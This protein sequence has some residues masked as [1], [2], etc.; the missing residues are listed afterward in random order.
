M[1]GCARHL[2][3]RPSP[4]VWLNF[5]AVVPV[6]TRPTPSEMPDGSSRTLSSSVFRKALFTLR[7]S[8]KSGSAVW[9]IQGATQRV[10]CSVLF[11]RSSLKHLFAPLHTPSLLPPLQAPRNCFSLGTPA[12][13]LFP[14]AFAHITP[15]NLACAPVRHPPRERWAIEASGA[16]SRCA[17]AASCRARASPTAPPSGISKCHDKRQKRFLCSGNGCPEDEGC[18]T[19]VTSPPEMSSDACKPY[20]QLNILLTANLGFFFQPIFGSHNNSN[21]TT[22]FGSGG[23]P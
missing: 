8:L 14:A 4:D 9:V 2:A 15:H 16:T 7:V 1:R 18:S 11:F 6:L 12:Q 13:P 17:G 22:Y 10:R 20:V 21:F 3:I 19:T 5:A 23:S